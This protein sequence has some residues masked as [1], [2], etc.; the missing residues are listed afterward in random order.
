M[1]QLALE[2]ERAV[3]GV[4]SRPDR[5]LSTLWAWL[6]EASP[7][8]RRARKYDCGMTFPTDIQVTLGEFVDRSA[9]GFPS[10]SG[11]CLA[12]FSRPPPRMN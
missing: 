6:G 9:L 1:V 11:N 7:W 5:G 2:M 3:V 4:A 8:S 12:R 10:T